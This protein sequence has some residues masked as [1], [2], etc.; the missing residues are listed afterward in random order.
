MVWAVAVSSIPASCW[1]ASEW[2][3]GTWLWTWKVPCVKIVIV[4][5]GP[6]TCAYVFFKDRSVVKT[7]LAS[8]SESSNRVPARTHCPVQPTLR[9]H[10][11][12]LEGMPQ[13]LLAAKYPLSLSHP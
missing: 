2:L 10:H 13:H 9:N 7:I 12:H 6:K 4:R 11:L 5:R 3:N 1:R 8:H